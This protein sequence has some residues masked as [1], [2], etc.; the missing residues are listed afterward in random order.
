MDE[1]CGLK[2][3]LLYV[4]TSQNINEI[5]I[6]FCKRRKLEPK[7]HKFWIIARKQGFLII[8]F[9]IFD[10][11]SKC[12]QFCVNLSR[13]LYRFFFSFKKNSYLLHHWE[14]W[15]CVNSEM[16]CFSV[17]TATV[18]LDT[19]WVS[20]SEILTRALNMGKN[21]CFANHRQWCDF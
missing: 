13:N 14:P 16:N 20:V 11:F 5:K 7:F 18:M 17:H 4:H 19:R 3:E 15:W 2:F 1:M 9:S 8:Y 10:N 12:L 6:I 21:T